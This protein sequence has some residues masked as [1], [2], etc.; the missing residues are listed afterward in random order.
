MN[1]H[2]T[3]QLLI[4]RVANGDLKFA[5]QA[6]RS[7]AQD[8]EKHAKERCVERPNVH[9]RWRLTVIHRTDQPYY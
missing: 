8:E 4:A 1:A 9:D 6:Q 2:R 5:A 3:K 7:H